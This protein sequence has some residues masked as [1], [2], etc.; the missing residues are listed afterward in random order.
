MLQENEKPPGKKDRHSIT[1]RTPK[2][3]KTPKMPKTPRGYEDE[4]IPNRKPTEWMKDDNE[5]H[6]K[7]QKQTSKEVLRDK[8]EVKE[9]SPSAMPENKFSV[10]VDKVSFNFFF[11]NYLFAN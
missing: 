1:P 10:T 3:P 4:F 11:K 8:N 9:S 7:V 5:A 6:G 2:T